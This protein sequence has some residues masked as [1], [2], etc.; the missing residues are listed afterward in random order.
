MNHSTPTSA[1]HRATRPP[2]AS[3]LAAMT[4]RPFWWRRNS[5]RCSETGGHQGPV[6]QT[7]L[8]AGDLT[9]ALGEGQCEQEREQDLHARL[10]DA[11]LLEQLVEVA[12]EPLQLAFLALA[13][14]PIGVWFAHVAPPPR[15]ARL[16]C[17]RVWSGS[18]FDP[19]RRQVGRPGDRAID[20]LQRP[21]RPF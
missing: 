12:V 7:T 5:S 20:R 4:T 18:V 11:Q 6:V 14:V 8:E 1:S 3:R 21:H 15:A 10:G 2:T 9:E 16:H 19:A 13:T 17:A